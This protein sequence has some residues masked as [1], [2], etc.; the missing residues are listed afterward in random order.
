MKTFENTRDLIKWKFQAKA[1]NSKKHKKQN[2]NVRNE[3][4]STLR[5]VIMT[6]ANEGGD[7]KTSKS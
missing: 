6:L 5:T 7:R 1:E 2:Q 4:D 3:N